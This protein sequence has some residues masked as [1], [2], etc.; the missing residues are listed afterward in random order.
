MEDDQKRLN[1][2]EM[3]E[4]NYDYEFAEYIVG[5]LIFLIDEGGINEFPEC[6]LNMVK[7]SI[8]TIKMCILKGYEDSGVGIK[9]I[10][11]ALQYITPL[12]CHHHVGTQAIDSGNSNR[13]VAE[14]KQ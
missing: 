7:Q 3:R 6:F 12:E 2:S 8:T 4:Y 11:E 9:Y 10:E 5:D 1:E 14:N 13:L